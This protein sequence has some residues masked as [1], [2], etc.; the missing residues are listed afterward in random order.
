[1]A[2]MFLPRLVY[3]VSHQLTRMARLAALQLPAST[4]PHRCFTTISSMPQTKR[5]VTPAVGVCSE[6]QMPLLGQ[7]QHLI[8]FQPVSGMKTKTALKRRCKDCFFVWRRGRLY[9]YCK[10][11]PRH[12]QRQ[13]WTVN[14]LLCDIATMFSQNSCVSV[15]FVCFVNKIANWSILLLPHYCIDRELDLLLDPGLL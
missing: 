15:V 9:V 5:I 13:G 14:N 1:M 10:T 8:C 3:S 11:H 12:K 6:T 2:A 4:S 7:C